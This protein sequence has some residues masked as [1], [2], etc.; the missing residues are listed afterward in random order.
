MSNRASVETMTRLLDGSRRPKN[1]PVDSKTFDRHFTDAL[2]A[3]SS[4]LVRLTTLNVTAGDWQLTL[5]ARATE[6]VC[7]FWGPSVLTLVTR[8]ELEAEDPE[9]RLKRGVPSALVTESEA[10]NLTFRIY[11][12]P[13]DAGTVRVLYMEADENAIPIVMEVPLA[14]DIL[15]RELAQEGPHQD[16]EMAV[17]LDRLSQFFFAVVR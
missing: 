12:T 11:P 2:V 17:L 14:L 8:A 1:L 16:A 15:R 4:W 3:R 7:A 5:P 9:W 13:E 10:T 6:L